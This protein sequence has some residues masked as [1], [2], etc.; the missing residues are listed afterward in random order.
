MS[1]GR[2]IAWLLGCVIHVHGKSVHFKHRI[3]H[4]WYKSSAYH[5]IS[6]EDERMWSRFSLKTSIPARGPLSQPFAP[7]YPRRNHASQ[8]LWK[9]G[10]LLA[11]LLVR[12]HRL[13]VRM[14]AIHGTNGGDGEGILYS[15][16]EHQYPLTI[17]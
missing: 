12:Y 1:R 11:I 13:Y 9:F 7:G 6:D 10:V 8:S 5:S 14:H 15:C 3:H 4:L 2:K 16:L 17:L